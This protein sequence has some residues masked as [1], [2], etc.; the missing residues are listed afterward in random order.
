MPVMT[1]S[2]EAQEAQ[3]AQVAQTI[4]TLKIQALARGFLVRKKMV[5]EQEVRE[6]HV[7]RFISLDGFGS[8]SSLSAPVPCTEASESVAA[9]EAAA[10]A[11]AKA[12]A[13]NNQNQPDSVEI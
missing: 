1:R 10:G 12:A 2:Q 3:V 8:F 13:G 6:A 9:A 5:Q 4:A 11:A 7:S